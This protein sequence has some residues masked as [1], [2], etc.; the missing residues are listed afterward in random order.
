MRLKPLK[1]RV[2][3]NRG[4]HVVAPISMSWWFINSLR[5]ISYCHVVVRLHND[6]VLPRI[7]NIKIHKYFKLKYL[8]GFECYSSSPL[9]SDF[10]LEFH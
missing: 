1:F 6:V 5:L 9:E 2:F 8:Q 7:Q 3:F 4:D 10:I